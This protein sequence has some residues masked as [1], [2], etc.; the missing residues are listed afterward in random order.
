MSAPGQAV[1]G[2]DANDHL[3]VVLSHPT[4]A[5][6]IA[7]ADPTTHRP[8][9][10]RHGQFCLLIEPGEH[11]FVRHTSC[12]AYHRATM[13]AV[14]PFDSNIRIGRFLEYQPFAPDLLNR[15]QQGA[16][17]APHIR[18]RIVA[19]IRATLDADV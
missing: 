1:T 19:A 9:R 6:T 5:D 15:I 7:V 18:G 16:L 12:V 3:W 13:K 11:P 17:A 14:R 2:V 10:K 8:H 4:R